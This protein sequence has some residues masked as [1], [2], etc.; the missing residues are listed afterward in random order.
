[1]GDGQTKGGVRLSYHLLCNVI[2]VVQK[3]IKV[4]N[5]QFSI[6]PENKETSMIEANLKDQNNVFDPGD[7]F[8]TQE[9]LGPI[10]RSKA[11]QIRASLNGTIQDFVTK[12]LAHKIE[13]EN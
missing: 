12:A 10:T 5:V 7:S 11:K 2:G 9:S 6:Q 4:S 3:I 1:M 13:K 8:D